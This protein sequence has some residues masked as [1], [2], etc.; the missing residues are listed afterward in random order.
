MDPDHKNQPHHCWWCGCIIVGEPFIGTDEHPYCSEEHKK[1]GGSTTI[2]F[3]SQLKTS[4]KGYPKSLD[5][6]EFAAGQREKMVDYLKSAL[7]PGSSV[8]IID[9]DQLQ[10]PALVAWFHSIAGHFDDKCNLAGYAAASRCSP[11]TS[12]DE[13]D[14]LT[15]WA[16]K[17]RE[18]G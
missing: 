14:K 1:K 13:I 18:K 2:S 16:A 15:G 3:L 10:Y 11:E 12:L 8:Q 7:Q 5:S 17:E 6:P 9:F 4:Q